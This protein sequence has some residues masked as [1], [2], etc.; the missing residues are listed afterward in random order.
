MTR[1]RSEMSPVTVALRKIIGK[2][3]AK[4]ERTARE[5]AIKHLRS[6]LSER[7]RIFPAEL[8]IEKPPRP[9]AKPQRTISVLVVDYERRRTVDVIVD[10]SGKV[11]RTNDLATFRP[12]FLSDEVKDAREIARRDPRVAAILRARGVI[13]SAFG[14]ERHQEPGPHL[15]GLRYAAPDGRRGLRLLAEVAVDLSAGTLRTFQAI[16][17]REEV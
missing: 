3:T 7:F 2:L 15:L 13:V 1:R 8:R 10:T 9:S 14:P 11:V 6:E 16:G 4:E 17:A 12:A 5:A